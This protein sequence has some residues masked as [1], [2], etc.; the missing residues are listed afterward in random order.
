MSLSSHDGG[1]GGDGDGDGDGGSHWQVV[2]TRVGQFLRERELKKSL[3]STMSSL[4]NVPD[5]IEADYKSSGSQDER[6][7]EDTTV[8]GLRESPGEWPIRQRL[9]VVANRLPVF[10]VRCDDSWSVEISDGSLVSALSGEIFYY[11]LDDVPVGVK[12]MEIWW[13]GWMGVDVP[14]EAGQMALTKALGDKNCVHVLLDEVTASDCSNYMWPL[15]HYH[16]LSDEDLLATTR[17]IHHTQFAAYRRANRMFADVICKHYKDGDIVWCQDYHLMLLPKFLKEYDINIKVGWFLQTPFLSSEIHQTL[18]SRR[19]VLHAVLAA[20]LLG[21]HTYDHARHFVSALGV[22]AVP[23][24]V[25]YQGRITRVAAV[26]LGVDRPDMIKT[27]LAFEKFIEENPEWHDKVVLL[28]IAVPTRTDLAEYQKLTSQVHENVGRINGKF[29]TL[30]EVPIH[31]LDRSLDFNALCA[32]YAITAQSLR[33]GALLVNPWNIKEVSD[34][35]GQALVMPAEEREKRH[36]VNFDHV[37]S[38]TA[39]RWAEFFISELTHNVIEAKQRVREI[40]PRPIFSEGINVYLQSENILILLEELENEVRR[41]SDTADSTRLQLE[42]KA[43]KLESEVKDTLDLADSTQKQLKEKISVL[44]SELFEARK[45]IKKDSNA[46]ATRVPMEL[47]SDLRKRLRPLLFVLVFICFSVLSAG[48]VF[49]DE[50]TTLYYIALYSYLLVPGVDIAV[51]VEWSWRPNFVARVVMD[52][53][54]MSVVPAALQYCTG[55]AALFL[56]LISSGAGSSSVMYVGMVTNLCMY[57][58]EDVY[59]EYL[60]ERLIRSSATWRQRYP[61]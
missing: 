57:I 53:V 42:D 61:Y 8:D 13:I 45:L 6:S 54:L 30:T 31:H 40:S 59:V 46:R 34:A 28:Q 22:E 26:M 36:L 60:Q 11:F 3:R 49:S 5:A 2:R 56:R 35:I 23:E 55:I 14:D 1:K 41:I 25:E 50:Y 18:P 15:F 24:G 16:A 9:L 7:S 10:A 48:L 39:Q 4:I 32:L 43:M 52:S 17:S 51:E 12:D 47:P 33:A 19:K 37:T 21:F 29:G 38:Y 44:E 20:D 27:L 58:F